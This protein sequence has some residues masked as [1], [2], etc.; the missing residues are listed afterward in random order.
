M[1][2]LHALFAFFALSS[3]VSGRMATPQKRAIDTCANIDLP[4]NVLNV[5]N[6]RLQLCA[7]V[8]VASTLIKENSSLYI[9]SKVLG[10]AD[11]KS[12]LAAAI[13][14]GQGKR[15]C[16]YPDYAIPSCSTKD[17]CNF[18]CPNDRMKVNGECV[19]KQGYHDCNGKCAPATQACSSQG[20]K[21]PYGGCPKCRS[22]HPIS[23]EK[24][25]RSGRG[26]P[27]WARRSLSSAHCPAGTEMCGVLGRPDAWECLNVDEDLE[28]CGGC[29]YPF[30]PSQQT[31]VDC[32]A[33]PGVEVVACRKGLC[34]VTK[35][36]SNWTISAD[37]HACEPSEHARNRKF[38][39]I[40]RAN[41]ENPD[42]DAV[43]MAPW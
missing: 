40:G 15:T 41:K 16:T 19:C 7:C 33:I 34:E 18:N 23:S 12:K 2:S 43:R 8:G 32:S 21:P 36:I 14:I 22:V 29:A 3:F 31:G 30:F 38:I 9:A 4:L 37:G 27:N 35:C 11:I 39:S 5:L 20:P 17:L 13:Q 10:E 6:L 26:T 1:R 24:N 25:K 42:A 28:S